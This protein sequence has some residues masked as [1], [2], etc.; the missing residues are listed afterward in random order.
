MTKLQHFGQQMQ[1][2][3]NMIIKHM[4]L[5]I[6]SSCRSDITYSHSFTVRFI[7]N[8]PSHTNHV[9]DFKTITV[10]HIKPNWHFDINVLFSSN[11]FLFLRLNAYSESDLSSAVHIILDMRLKWKHTAEDFREPSLSFNRSFEATSDRFFHDKCH[12]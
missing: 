6:S 10:H 4:K 2:L 11:V 1:H 8:C 9:C 5:H 12:V 7:Q 3:T